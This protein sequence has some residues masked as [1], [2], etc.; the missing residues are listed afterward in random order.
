VPATEL[1]NG[2]VTSRSCIFTTCYF[3]KISFLLELFLNF[4]F[5]FWKNKDARRRFEL[6][7]IPNQALFQYNLRCKSQN[8]FFK[9][10]DK[11]DFLDVYF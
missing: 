2:F 6:S 4:E 9:N 5:E 10:T 3:T 11:T 7:G 8:I 1:G